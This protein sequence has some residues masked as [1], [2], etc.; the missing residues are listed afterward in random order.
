MSATL[1]LETTSEIETTTLEIETTSEIEITSFMNTP[2][3]DGKMLLGD[4]ITGSGG[5]A[6]VTDK[7]TGEVLAHVAVASAEDVHQ[8]CNAAAEAAPAWAATPAAERATI[9]RRAGQL[10]LEHKDE[11]I[12]WLVRESGSTRFKAEFEVQNTAVHFENSAAFALKPVRT[13]VSKTEDKISYYDRVPLGVVGVIGPFNFPLILGLRSVSAAI[14]TG[15]TVVLKPSLN[16]AVS[17]GILIARLFEEAGLPKG[18]LS[19]LPGEGPAGAVLS[20]NPNVNM[21]AFTG[22]TNV[23]KKIGASAGAA[24]KR[25]S[26]ELGGKNPFIVLPEADLELAARAG[27]FGTFFHQG[28][29]CMA[30]G[31][32]LVHESLV[33]AYAKRVAELGSELKVGDPWKEQVA[34]GP[35]INE[36]QVGNI[37]RIVKETVAAGAELLEGGTRDGLFYRPTVLKNVPKDSPAFKE[38]I[39]G[40][41]ATIIPF[42]TE[43]EALAIA[44]GTG[45]GLSSAV[46]GELNHA[47]AVGARIDAGMVHINDQTVMED[48]R[49]PFGGS[50]GSGN[51]THIGGESDLEEYTTFRWTTETCKP[52][53][54]ILPNM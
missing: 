14:A 45:F 53:P 43:E 22:S 54:Y 27:A 5:V 30:T 4:W 18:V 10:L 17:G 26:L 20:E 2:I 25:V 11:A 40:P 31:L 37:D 36:K 48:A 6:D 49:V 24:L 34:L 23:G 50:H 32:H 9:V 28:Q 44:N 8:A 21:V 42:K 16:T 52:Q 33:D 19:V 41:V 35:I 47:K 39:F 38:E 12:Y 3:W 46:F 29:I 1:E 13:V 51:P 7:A 15:N